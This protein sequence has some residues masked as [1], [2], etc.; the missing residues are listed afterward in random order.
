MKIKNGLT[1]KLWWIYLSRFWDVCFVILLYLLECCSIIIFYFCSWQKMCN[2]LY[3]LHV[4]VFIFLTV[5]MDAVLHIF[6]HAIWMFICS[7]PS[8]KYIM[9]YSEF[10]ARL[11]FNLTKW[12]LSIMLL[13]K[14]R[15]FIVLK[16]IASLAVG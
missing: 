13:N 12:F 5:I 8:T 6:L 1:R 2:S 10:W 16:D 14:I 9:L 3:K 4:C 11:I 7:N 15:V